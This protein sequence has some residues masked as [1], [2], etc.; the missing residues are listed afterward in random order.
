MS[1]EITFFDRLV[2]SRWSWFLQGLP[3][4]A[5]ATALFRVRRYTMTSPTRCKHLWDLSKRVLDAS[6]PG[7]FVECGVWRGGSAGIMGLVLKARGEN[8][9]LQLFDSFAGLPEPTIEDGTRAAEYSGGRASGALESVD[10]CRAGLEDVRDFLFNQLELDATRVKFHIG[11][12]QNTVPEVAPAMNPIAVLRLDGD[13]YESTRIC[14]D[15]LYPLVSVGGVVI[16]DDFYCWQ[17]C[18]KA[19]EEF[20]EKFGIT[21]PIQRIDRDAAFWKVDSKIPLPATVA[22]SG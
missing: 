21:A 16:L 5:R 8:R 7:D 6:I 19:A 20:R 22:S 3:S 11:W 9:E 1:G 17:G 4:V 18:A 2:Q 13:W 15:F 10:Q 12:F 14:L